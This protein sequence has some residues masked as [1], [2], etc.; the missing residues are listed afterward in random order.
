MTTPVSVLC[1]AAARRIGSLVVGHWSFFLF[2]ILCSVLIAPRAGFSGVVFSPTMDATS[3]VDIRLE[4]WLETAPN[5]GFVPVTIRIRNGDSQVHTWVLSSSNGYGIGGGCRADAE[6]TVEAGRDGE[7]VIYAPVTAH[8]DRGYYYGALSFTVSGYGVDS[9]AAGSVTHTSGYGGTRT[10]YIGMSKMLASKHWSSLK[11]RLNTSKAAARSDLEGSEVDM[12][13]AP[14]DWRGYSGLAQLWMEESEWMGMRPLAKAAMLD[15]VAMGGRVYVLASDGSEARAKELGLPGKINDARRYGA[16]EIVLIVWDGKGM[17]LDDMAREIRRADTNGMC[18]QLGGYDKAWDLRDLA[19]N[20]SLKSGLIFGFIAIFGILVGPVNL[21][22]LAPAGKRQRMFW[23]TPLLSLAGSVLLVAIMILQDGIGGSGARLTLA[24]LQPEQKRLA[25]MQEQVSRTGV[26]LRRS[27]PIAETGWMQP[28]ELA[29]AT[30]FNPLR[31]NRYTFTETETSRQGDWF[32]SRSVQA[33]LLETVR[34]SRA[35]IELLAAAAGQPPS[36]LS[37]IESSL[38]ILFIVDESNAVWM[39]EDVGTG[40]RKL[41]IPSTR[42]QLDA[43]LRDGPKKLAGPVLSAAMAALGQQAGC[44]FAEATDASKLAVPTLSS[45]R[46]TEDRA[47]IAGP[48][49]K[50]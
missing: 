41:T 13:A 49:L 27:F 31:E 48:F 16:G 8:T 9:S 37:N 46:W 43:W 14:E 45:I 12:A 3:H 1:H 28:L 18:S 7:R 20:L 17:R 5:F 4:S 38:K 19:G 30:G 33:H 42:A 11:N 10:E 36:V 44:V 23:T 29:K 47:I 21:F 25:I 39:A 32:A 15:W 22:W 6:M 35:A 2:F 24:I 40:E 26:L 50:R 34:P